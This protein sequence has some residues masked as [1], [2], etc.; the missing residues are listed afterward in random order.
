M[1]D[2]TT[3]RIN[4][5]LQVNGA[6]SYVNNMRQITGSTDTFNA[7]AG[8]LM[9]TLSKFISAAVIFNF[10]KQAKEAWQVQLEAETKLNTILRRNIGATE[11]QVQ[12]VKDWAS[13]LQKVGVIGDEIQLEG[14]QEL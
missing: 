5:I 3:D 1:S 4:I 6:S 9:A 11:E 12:V 2:L 14:L 8:R 13:E 10:A 7:S